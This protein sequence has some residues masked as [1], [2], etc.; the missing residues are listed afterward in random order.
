MFAMLTTYKC[1]SLTIWDI[2]RELLQGV[3]RP[4]FRELVLHVNAR[5][6]EEKGIATLEDLLLHGEALRQIRLVFLIVE[7]Y[8]VS[9]HSLWQTM[10]KWSSVFGRI[11]ATHVVKVEYSHKADLYA[12]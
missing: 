3:T 10:S 11:K 1:R 7:G 4:T 5:D 9:V 8:F 12:D 2:Y 6:F